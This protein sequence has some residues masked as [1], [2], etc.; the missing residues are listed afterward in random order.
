MKEKRK[1]RIALQKSGRLAEGSQ[2]LLQKCGMKL[3]SNKNQLFIQ[4]DA[5]GIEF[6]FARDDDIPGL[7]KS[8]VCYLGI[9]GEN[10]LKEYCGKNKERCEAFEII[11]PLGFSRCRLSIAIPKREEY[12]K[13]E[14]LCGKTIATSYPKIL[15]HFLE[16]NHIDAKIVSM[17]GS[18]E[19]APQIG[20][21]DLICDLVSSGATLKE[22]GLREF[23][24]V[25]KSEAI[26]VKNK[27][28]NISSHKLFLE[29]FILRIKSVLN[30]QKN[31][32]LMLHID[33]EK[34]P[35]LTK[36]LPGKEAPTI[37][38]LKDIS[39]KVAIHLVT[40]E[41]IFWETIEK[42][43]EIGASSILV[44]PIEKMIE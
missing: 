41:D 33:R 8:G 26:L 7:I 5:F 18:V 37:L 30:A 22:N 16:K 34:I 4:D 32:Y 3:N 13:L 15:N 42:V 40:A 2:S 17:H 1:I 27:A 9:I 19:L 39:D 31:K 20:I 10:L 29:R 43:K 36:I 38:E 14:D 23:I 6:I 11:M 24:K 12:K 21:A 25:M 28:L 44:L 35:L